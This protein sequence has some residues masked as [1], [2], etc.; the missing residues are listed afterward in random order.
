MDKKEVI[1]L[2]KE[3][4]IDFYNSKVWEDYTDE[5]L[6]EFQLFQ[7]VLCV[8]FNKFHKAIEAVLDRPVFTHEF[9]FGDDNLRKE[10]QKIRSKSTLVE[11]L[12]QIPEDKLMIVSI[13]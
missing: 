7:E 1:Q 4:A 5:Q 12:V 8:P 13:E 6:V 11:V 10:Y 3:E 2:T 9:G